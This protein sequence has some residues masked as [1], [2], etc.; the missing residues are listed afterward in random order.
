MSTMLFD[1]IVYGPVRSRRLGC[2]LGINL[3]PCDG[4]RCTFDCIYCE[5]GLNRDRSTLTASPNVES[6]IKALTIKSIQMQQ[7]GVCPDVITFSGNGEPTMNP[8]FSQIIDAVIELRNKKLPKTKIAVLSNST[9]L[10]K[11]GVIES[12]LKV[13]EA[14]MKI[15]AVEDKLIRLIDQPLT[16]DFNTEK[17]ISHLCRF[18]GKLIIQTM[19]LKGK[20][21]GYIVDNTEDKH[22]DK[23]CEALQLINPYKVMIYTID[24][25][26]PVS[27]LQKVTMSELENIAQKVRALNIPVSVSV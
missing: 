1:T 2:S 20:Y 6:V 22:V 9:M 10:N 13:D 27:T 12:L 16:K 3:S 7:E 25:E 15:D 17:L 14:L 5:C 24:R 18:N 26:T 23:W 21:N 19:F 4:K 11:E 8:Q